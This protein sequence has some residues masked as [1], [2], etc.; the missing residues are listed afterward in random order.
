MGRATSKVTY[1]DQWVFC[2]VASDTLFGGRSF[3]DYVVNERVY[4][5]PYGGNNTWPKA[6]PNFLC[7]R[8][9]GRVQQ[10]NRVASFEILP[11]LGDRWPSLTDEESGGPHIVYTLGPD[12]PIPTIST[13]GTY[14]NGR[15]WCLLDQLLVHPTLADAARASAELRERA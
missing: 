10:V 1:D 14:A 2:V 4:F 12:I 11:H 8:W 6:A 3:K 13:K 7:F 5:H 9:A 15:I